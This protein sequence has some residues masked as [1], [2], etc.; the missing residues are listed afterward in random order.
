MRSFH[1]ILLSLIV[2]S[3]V[4]QTPPEQPASPPRPRTGLRL[5][6]IPLHDPYVLVESSTRTYHLYN[7]ASARVTGRNRAGT[8][9]YRSKDLATW[10]GPFLVFECPDDSWAMSQV[11]AWAPEVHAYR[12]RYYLLTTLHN[13]GKPLPS[14]LSSEP[15]SMRATVIAVSDSPAG[16]CTL[17]KKDGPVTPADFMTLDG[18]L[19]VDP[20]GKPWM[21]YA[22]EWIQKIDG[23]IEALPLKDDLSAAAGDPV[24]LFKGSDAPWIDE[25]PVPSTRPALYV[26][27]G[28]E[29]FRTKTGRL[30]MLWSSY[31]R[32]SFGQDG[33][34]QT[35]ARSRSGNL[36]GPW[37]QLP[38]LVRNDSGHG[39]LF[40]TFEGQLMLILHQPFLQAR[41]KLYEV[42]DLG[43]SLRV[44]RYR[45]DLSGPPLG[46]QRGQVPR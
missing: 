8:V 45:E 32:N 42:E 34:V 9:A 11:K 29:L 17:M 10:E 7:S 26:T 2:V 31:A 23:T 5:P 39:I 6:E 12:G 3:A 28:P 35:I 22:H 24:F 13:P 27:D 44:G 33:Y 20:A 38:L 37:E 43:D 4:A 15:N 30:L 1:A 16:P 21:V 41:G 40:R 18:T 14:A 19:Y 46:P 25:Q 36:E